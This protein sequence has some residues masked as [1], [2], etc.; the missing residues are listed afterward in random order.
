MS[1]ANRGAT[2]GYSILNRGDRVTEF[3]G[4]I[5]PNPVGHH[6]YVRSQHV[7]SYEK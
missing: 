2:R 1:L 5:T 6:M 3:G 4:E 7:F